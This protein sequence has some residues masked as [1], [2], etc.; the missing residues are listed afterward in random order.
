MVVI[1]SSE[2]HTQLQRELG[3][4]KTP[5]GEPITVLFLEKSQGVVTRDKD[6]MRSS[7]NAAIKEN[8]FGD[9][10]RTL[11]PA[12]QSISFNDVA[13]FRATEGKSFQLDD[14]AKYI[15]C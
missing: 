14:P 11:S 4:Q 12:T 6:F 7:Q 15:D 2:L 3:N 8:F 1:G 13:I 9:S 5:H 10:K